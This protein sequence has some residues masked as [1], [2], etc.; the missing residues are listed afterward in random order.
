EVIV[1]DLALPDGSGLDLCGE[2][3]A[4]GVHVGVVML[5]ASGDDFDRV[6]GLDVGADDYLVKPCNP[7]ELLARIHAVLRRTVV[8]EVSVMRAQTG[9]LRSQC[10]P[11]PLRAIQF[12]RCTLDVVSRALARDGKIV[13]HLT[14]A[15]FAMLF[16]LVSRPGQTLSRERLARLARG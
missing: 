3:R 8:P 5:S 2:L 15:E 9:A 6:A 10:A 4:R 12:G 11:S 16:A 1:L 7:R 14:M 13:A